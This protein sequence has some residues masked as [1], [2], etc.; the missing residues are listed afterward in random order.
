MKRFLLTL[1]L[2]ISVSS[3]VYAEGEQFDVMIETVELPATAPLVS[4]FDVSY[5]S[6][7]QLARVRLELNSKC[8][9]GT[10]DIVNMRAEGLYQQAKKINVYVDAYCIKK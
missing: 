5:L 6:M 10:V 4:D 1:I 8:N 7:S 2:A 3:I 9:K